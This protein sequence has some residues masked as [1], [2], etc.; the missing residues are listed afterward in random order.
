M[1]KDFAS[2][3]G[4]VFKE[5]NV[6]NLVIKYDPNTRRTFIG[7]VKSREIRTFYKA[8]HRDEDPFEAAVKL[9]KELSGK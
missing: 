3:S 7:H 8:D 5:T 9:A 2:E 6:G 1:A 4:S